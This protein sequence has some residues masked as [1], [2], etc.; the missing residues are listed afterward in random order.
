MTTT[1]LP[2]FAVPS[3]FLIA[4]FVLF[5]C[6]SGRQLQTVTLSPLNADA[7]SFPNGQ[8]QFTATGT[9][10]QPPSPVQL[11]SNDISWCMGGLGNPGGQC[12]GNANPGGTVTQ[13]G[14]AQ[15]NPMFTGTTTVLA[16]VAIPVGNPM[17]DSGAQFKVFGSATLTCP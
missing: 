10:S 12:V 13:N 7:Q 11:T 6:G 9:F 3:L 1:R 2:M 5:G 17:P 14:L 4:S 15:C 8:V 16:G